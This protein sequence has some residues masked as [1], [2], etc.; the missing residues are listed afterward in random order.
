MSE[1]RA[2]GLIVS[3]G[4]MARARALAVP[5]GAPSKL[6]HALDGFALRGPR[7][8]ATARGDDAGVVSG[9]VEATRTYSLAA[10]AA[11]AGELLLVALLPEGLQV[12]TL[13]RRG[14]VSVGRDASC[15][16]VIEHPSISRAHATIEVGDVVLVRDSGSRNGTRLG[17]LALESGDAAELAVGATVELGEL[18]LLLQRRGA[19]DDADADADAGDEGTPLALSLP[20]HDA[21]LGGTMARLLD[22]IRRVA[23]GELTILVVGE[24]GVGKDLAAELVHRA[25]RRAKGPF[26][27]LHCAALSPSLFE[28]EIFGH[29]RGA[30]T[31]A[32]H[33][34]PGLIETAEGGT[35]FL[36]EV[37]EISMAM[38][39]KLLRVLEDR[40]VA[41]VGSTTPR[42]VDVRF[43]AATNRDLHAEVAAGRFREDLYYRIAGFTVVVPP[44]RDRREEVLPLA[45]M[46]LARVRAD[47]RLVLSESAKAALLAY[48][49][50]GNVRE[51]RLAIERAAALA[52][53]E[54]IEPA[55]LGLDA[56]A[57]EGTDEGAIARVLRETSGN[58]TEAA[59]RLGISRR[60][61][62]SRLAVL[63]AA[64]R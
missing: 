28:S 45:E 48:A 39:V 32:T 16:V 44:L 49:F 26:V 20:D 23:V 63:R 17:G 58:Q 64:R 51:L 1:V 54:V 33:A 13:P 18:T 57:D 6:A 50:P 35:L 7:R 47:R 27:R 9:A 59:R 11:K 10:R 15:D 3:S 14:A 46:F 41:R 56:G 2:R 53:G 52:R 31:G 60:T 19:D 4:F 37:G 43:V 55:E 5:Q 30:F 29:E 24:T 36:D 62:V 12:W 22:L 21:L 42:R 38:Q 61:L 8:C 34:K 25:S 40:R